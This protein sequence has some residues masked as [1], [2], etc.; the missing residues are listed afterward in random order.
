MST[1]ARRERSTVSALGAAAFAG[2]LILA[3]AAFVMSRASTTRNPPAPAASAA[4]GEVKIAPDFTA[5]LIDGGSFALSGE[6]G[7][8]VLILF[9]ASWCAPCIPEVNKMAQLQE[10]F[11][12]RGLRQI[13]LSIDPG[14]RP[15]DFDG[16]RRRTLGSRLNWGLDIEQRALRAYQ[17]LATDTKVLVDP[18]GR[19]SFTSVG[20]TE[21]ET[22][23]REVAK[24]LR[25]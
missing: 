20:A 24:L 2:V 19:I 17:I 21:Y 4:A 1:R 18:E 15:S 25:A 23:R 22:L 13:V 6:R 3:G 8:P 7:H 10:E 9:T 16:L 14:D 11:G 12:G 5:R